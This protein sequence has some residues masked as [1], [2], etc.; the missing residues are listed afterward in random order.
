MVDAS[1]PGDE[2]RNRGAIGIT[3]CARILRHSAGPVFILRCQVSCKRPGIVYCGDVIETDSMPR[4]QHLMPHL[5]ALLRTLHP[6]GATFEACRQRYGAV[7]RDLAASGVGRIT[8]SRVGDADAYWSPTQE[9]LD[10]AM[11]LGWVE[12]A[13]TPSARKYLDEYRDRVYTPTAAGLHAAA[14]V[15]DPV[16][17]TDMV[18]AAV[19]NAHATMR[20]MLV[21]LKHA[22]LIVPEAN[23]SLLGEATKSGSS[24]TDW[25]AEWAAARINSGPTGDVVTA[26]DVRAEVTQWRTKR[27]GS[28]T[29]DIPTRKA[30]VDMIDDAF[31][32]VALKVRDLPVGPIAF[33]VAA[34][35]GSSLRLL[36]QSRYVPAF[37]GTNVIW[38]ACDLTE[39]QDEEAV[40][41]HSADQF[42]SE[43]LGVGRRAM[44]AYGRLA[45]ESVVAAYRRQAPDTSMATPYLPLH[46]VR[47]E[48]TYNAG[49]TRAL[50]DMAIE[51]LAAGRWPD[52]EVDVF[53]HGGAGAV[54]ASEPVYQRGG[55]RTALSIQ[56]HGR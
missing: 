7:A 34:G 23:E 55:R 48:A 42:G 18:T 17:F 8:V 45:A 44:S 19:L 43:R 5:S 47:A 13:P 41:Q 24:P 11:R 31:A 52:L 50:G 54:P 3:R 30:L 56:A 46:V 40:V 4:L 25:L 29:A 16:A 9:V 2:G 28:S 26:D 15:D 12:K 1:A 51:A 14:R 49:V 27:F 6:R 38:L 33:R 35:W 21:M 37:E 20:S 32:S 22:P 53:L 39:P 10:E 36:D